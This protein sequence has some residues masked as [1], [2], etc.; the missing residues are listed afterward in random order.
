[1]RDAIYPELQLLYQFF[2]TEAGHEEPNLLY[3][4]SDLEE[5]SLHYK[6]DLADFHTLTNPDFMDHII[7]VGAIFYQH[8]DRH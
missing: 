5:I 8:E 4:K 7:R 3:E 1:M 2:L 6:V